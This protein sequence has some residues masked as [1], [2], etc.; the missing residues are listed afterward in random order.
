M[1][2]PQAH[3]GACALEAQGFIPPTPSW[4]HRIYRTRT[5]QN[6]NRGSP[7]Q[8]GCRVRTESERD[9]VGDV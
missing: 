5:E 9:S 1:E 3:Q 4:S 6:R 8:G 2:R 7:A